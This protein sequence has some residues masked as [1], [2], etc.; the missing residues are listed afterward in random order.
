MLMDGIG[1]G[2]TPRLL[3]LR[4][5]P[6]P[7]SFKFGLPSKKDWAWVFVLILLGGAFGFAMNAM[8]DPGV[9]INLKIALD[10][11]DPT[12]AATVQP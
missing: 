2:R 10:L 6:M 4:K 9:G 5:E 1:P 8:A 7:S 3:N 11:D 12:P